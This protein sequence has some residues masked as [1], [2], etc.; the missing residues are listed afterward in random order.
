[1]DSLHAIGFY[2]SSALSVGGALLVA[3]LNDRARRAL[4]LLVAGIGVAGLYASLAAGFAAIVVFASFAA[5]AALIARPEV[6]GYQW[7]LGGVWRQVGA[8]GA[9]LMFAGLAYAAYRGA[10]AH[11]TFN[12]GAFGAAA[13]G[14][15]LFA[16]DALAAEAIAALI[17]VV[18]IAS[19]LV[20]RSR[21]R[22][23][24]G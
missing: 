12:G 17:A 11:I 9:A 19:T 24:Q 16:R 3:F 2:V 23:R 1:M 6:R 8:A 4:A 10:F 5:C 7:A 15:L 20:W 21:E 14:R 22:G 13:V 18:L